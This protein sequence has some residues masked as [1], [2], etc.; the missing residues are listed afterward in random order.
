M[1]PVIAPQ[2][3]SAGLQ[4][5]GVPC[6]IRLRSGKADRG[7][8]TGLKLRFLRATV[9]AIASYGCESWA[10]TKTDRKRIDA[11]EMWSYRR[12]LRVSREDKRSNKWVLG[13]IGSDMVLQN[14]ILERKLRY[15][16]HVI[17]KDT[18]IEKQVIQG[19]VD[20]R[21]SWQRT[22]NNIM[23]RW[24][25]VM[26][27]R[28][29]GCGHKSGTGQGSMADPHQDHSSAFGHHLTRERERVLIKQL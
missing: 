25:Q 20:R 7:L 16:G 23:D 13:R 4:W 6:K 10:L 19:A 26:E 28:Q 11:F 15:F 8:S 12:L 17:R 2:R 24:H 18:S 27:W 22:S 21:S 29:Y 3:L 14:N 1:L 9:F 5:P